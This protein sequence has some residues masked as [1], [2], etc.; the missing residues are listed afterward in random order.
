MEV[1]MGSDSK[2][3]K[4]IYCDRGV[5]HFIHDTGCGRWIETFPSWKFLERHNFGPTN[6]YKASF[7]ASFLLAR[8]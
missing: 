2:M 5:A 6:A 8:Y 1:S 7:S 4:Y 3:A